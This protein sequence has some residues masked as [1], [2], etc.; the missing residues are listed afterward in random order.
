MHVKKGDTVV[1]TT[2]KD[3]GKTG[4][5]VRSLPVRQMVIVE[6]LNLKNRRTKPRRA[7]EAGQTVK[8][9]APIHVSNVK[10]AEKTATKKPVK[11]AA[12]K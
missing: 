9:S 5:I 3:K 7:K 8:F 6:G 10:L 1:V 12:K 11:K 4:K 2:G